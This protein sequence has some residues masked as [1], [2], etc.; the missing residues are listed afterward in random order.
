[1]YPRT[2]PP[3][4]DRVRVGGRELVVSDGRVTRWCSVSRAD[5]P[6]TDIGGGGG[7][8]GGGGANDAYIVMYLRTRA[9]TF[10]YGTSSHA[11]P[12]VP[13]AD[14]SNELLICVC[15][16]YVIKRSEKEKNSRFAFIWF[17]YQIIQAIYTYNII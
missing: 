17:P 6:R 8:G 14:Y 9:Y 12:P 13:A 4:D 11:D 2:T 7:G 10:D 16:R 15:K 5:Y 3:T 1:M